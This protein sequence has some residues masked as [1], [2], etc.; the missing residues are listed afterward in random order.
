LESFDI[1]RSKC[2]HLSVGFEVDYYPD[3]EQEIAE[4]LDS[5]KGELDIVVGAVHELAP[6]QPI[7]V[8]LQLKNLLKDHSFEELIAQYFDREEKMVESRLFSAIAHPDVIFRYCGD[9]LENRPE[10]VT[11]PRL[12]DLG[13]LCKQKGVRMEMNVRGLLY[14]CKRSFP[15]IEAAKIFLENGI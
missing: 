14:P 3:K 12:L 1:A 4:F 15:S 10:Y 5:Y 7:T 8:A 6:L 13:K 2:Q 9:V 11:H